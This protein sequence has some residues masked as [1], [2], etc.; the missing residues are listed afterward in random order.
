MKKILALVCAAMMMAGTMNAEVLLKESFAQQTEL[1]ADNTNVMANPIAETG[2]TN[3]SLSGTGIYVSQETDLTYS[4]YKSATDNTGSAWFKAVGKA[5]ATPLSK[6]ITNDG[7]V[8][9]VFVAGILNVSSIGASYQSSRD[10]IWAL[11][12]GTSSLNN[13]SVDRFLRLNMRLGNGDNSFQ[14]AV[15]KL[16]E[17]TNFQPWTGDLAYNKNYLIVTEYRYVEGEKNDS[18]FLYINPGK[19]DFGKYTLTSKQDTLQSGVTQKGSTSQVDAATFGSMMLISVSSVKPTLYFD[20]IKVA[21]SWADLFEE[22]GDTPGEDT[23]VINAASSL[24]F[25]SVNLNEAAEKTLTV[26]GSY[27]KGAINVASSSALVVPAVSTISKDAAEASSGYGL[28]LTLTATE[29][30]AGSANITFSSTDATSQVVNVSWNAAAPAAK[31]ANIAALKGLAAWGDPVDMESQPVVIRVTEEGAAVQDASGAMFIVD[32]MGDYLNLKAGDKVALGGLQTIESKYYVETYP[33]AYAGSISVLSSGNTLEPIEVTIAE[34]EQYGPAYVKVSGVTFPEEAE[35]FAAGNIAISQSGT[36]VNMYILAGNNIIG[37]DVPASADVQGCVMNWYGLKLQISSSADVFNR[38]PKGGDVP[39]YENLIQNPSFE[40]YSCN[41]MGCQFE[42]WGMALGSGSANSTDKLEGEVSLYINPTM[43]T[44]L[45]QGVALTDADYA[46]GSKFSMALNY[47][48]V[49]LPEGANLDLDCYWEPS[50]SGDAEAMKQHEADILQRTIATEVSS[51]WKELVLTTSKPAKSAYFRVRVKVPK[52]AKVLFDAFSLTYTPSTDPYIEVSPK[53]LPQFSLNLG[54]R[55]TKTVHIRQGNLSG[56][57]TFYIGGK[58]K[59]Q[60]SL[61]ATELPADQSDLDL[62]ITYA[63]TSAGTHAA[64]LIFDNAAHTTILP[65]MISLSGTCSDPSAKPVLTVTPS[66]LPD[67]E[68]LEGKQ[69][70]MTVTLS[71]INCTDYVYAHVDHISPAEHGAFTIYP[72]MFS[73]NSE[74]EVTITFSPLQAG[75]YQSTITFYS[76]GADNVVLTLNG[77]GIAKT[78]ETIDWQTDFVWNDAN[79]LSWMYESFDDIQHNETFV[80]EGWQNVAA[81][82]QR[83]WQGVDASTMQSIE[84]DGKFVRATAYQYGKDSTATWETWL[85]TP[86]LDYKKAESKIFAFSVM[87]MY[88][89]DDGNSTT[90]LEVYYMDAT[91]ETL[92]TED[93]T[94]FIS[95]PT[96]SDDNEDWKTFYVNLEQQ[97]YIADVFHVGFRFVGPNGNQGSVTYYI[98]DVSWGRTDLPTISVTPSYIAET[99]TLNTKKTIGT[100]EISGKNLTE[101]ITLSLGGDNYDHF[102]LS[103]TSLPAEGGSVEVYFEGEQEGVHVAYVSLSSKDAADVYVAFEI[104]CKRAEGIEEVQRDK[105]Q[106][107]KVLREG[108]IIILRDGK[109]FNL[110]GIRVE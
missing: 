18:V 67:F 78:P 70:Q 80:K 11:G 44:V 1:L 26:K 69:Q 9:S 37:E 19:D 109:S 84:G 73:K 3:V 72:A 94:G 53:T 17:A 56:K 91:G 90:K 48:V 49:A 32:G 58:D 92:Y 110:L 63:P 66:T 85:V 103:T 61:S 27:L 8:K 23:P 87:G 71:S 2:W 39:V 99:A 45:D 98:D 5:A 51:E 12:K 52:G 81:V 16:N 88:L 79:P 22:G 95:I 93:W 57:T 55:A 77:T 76:E 34:L 106:S 97:M 104:L 75:T 24:D 6:S 50:G 96:T 47:K 105:V 29:V 13:T 101:G 82:D 36:S 68:V 38:V 59:D 42:D 54:E 83:P 89:P 15:S 74:A 65:D 41:F 60:F 102:S 86:A 25:G 62:I 43:A 28:K 100:L 30:G 4:G 20:E 35:K 107:T 108:R 21:T 33:T 31:I 46:A 7:S 14:L 64:S 10:C 40:E